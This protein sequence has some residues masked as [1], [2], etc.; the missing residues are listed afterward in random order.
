MPA[1]TPIE[2]LP[3]LHEWATALRR[4]SSQPLEFCPGFRDIALRFEAWWAQEAIDR[5]IFMACVNTDPSRPITRRLDLLHQPA[6]W[7]EQKLLDLQQLRPIGDALPNIRVDFGPVLLGALFGGRLEF[8]SDTGWTH[9][10]IDDDW[11]NEPDW[12]VHPD[13]PWYQQLLKLVDLVS[14]CAA[15]QY[16]VCTPD[17]GGSADV[18]LNLRG[19]TG[20]CLDVMDR[21][22]RL[23]AAIDAIYPA[24]RQVF[25]D[26][27]RGATRHGAGLI[28]WLGLWSDR[29]YV[30]PACDFNAMI[31][32]RQFRTLCLP[33][34]DRQAA[35]VGRAVFHLDGPDAAR[36][37]DDILE[38]PHI[39]A[40]QFTPGAGSPSAVP[41]LP[42]FQKIQARGRSL[43]V[44]CPPNEILEVCRGLSWEGL[45]I[46]V[47]A[48]LT[49]PQ[50][51]DLL[52]R[53]LRTLLK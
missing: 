5:P 32:P 9:A 35:S 27:Y 38:V 40:V 12:V 52:A 37:I 50:L 30:I 33:D 20:L 47:E 23:R 8:G 41:W 22:E 45:A 15:G 43:L 3:E 24:W 29:P 42:M 7:L 1:R 4:V 6:V 17:L 28:H 49:P 36:H 21:P 13:N 2:P 51:D 34:I 46:L 18:L 26:L 31:S 39:Q 11:S 14:T 44:I 48:P 10:F 16:L 53:T 19:A 25:S